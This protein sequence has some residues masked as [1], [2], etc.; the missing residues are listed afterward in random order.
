MTAH[1]GAP[2]GRIGVCIAVSDPRL[3]QRMMSLLSGDSRLEVFLD[4]NDSR[5]SDVILADS[6]Q[7]P[8]G[9]SIIIDSD[10][11]QHAMGG[12]V[13]AVLPPS[14]DGELLCA[15]IRVV[16][17]GFIIL[18]PNDAWASNAAW[19][20]DHSAVPDRA[21]VALTARETQVLAL[22]ARGASNKLV[23]REL[24][25]SIHTA[26]FHV[27]S[28]LAKLGARNRSDAVAIGIRLGLILL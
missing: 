6:V 23:A 7:V 4:P 16:S 17:A 18:G 10:Q 19:V 11:A 9:L 25:I 21:A 2:S 14:V 13:R 20:P 5:S 8:P 22:L 24:D 12:Y 3:A 1:F 28:V 26:K 15:A 27:A